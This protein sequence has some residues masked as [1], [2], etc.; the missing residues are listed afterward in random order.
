MNNPTFFDKEDILMVH[1]D[2]DYDDYKT[3]DTSRIDETSFIE[4]VLQRQHQPY[5]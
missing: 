2:E 5:D 3:L 1:Q 4:P